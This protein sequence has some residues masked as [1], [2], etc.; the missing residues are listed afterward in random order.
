MAKTDII[1]KIQA[2]AGIATKA[3]ASKVLDAV[4]GAIQETLAAGDALT[5]TGFGAFKVSETGRPHRSRS[6]HRQDHRH[7]RV[8][9][10]AFH[11]GQDA[12]GCREVDGLPIFRAGKA[13]GNRGLFVV[14]GPAVVQAWQGDRDTLFAVEADRTRAWRL[15]LARNGRS[16]PFEASG[17]SAGRSPLAAGGCRY[18]FGRK[19][20]LYKRKRCPRSPNA[21]PL[22]P[23]VRT[24]IDQG[25]AKNVPNALSNPGSQSPTGLPRPF[26]GDAKAKSGFREP[27]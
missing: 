2:N 24:R 1:A 19:L 22:F 4:L 3:E 8:Q 12:Q 21:K 15:V 27:P 17:V 10:R 9:G 5:L 7:S 25:L 11:P 26:Q 20:F 23:C 18:R 14:S 6:P 13:A 16:N